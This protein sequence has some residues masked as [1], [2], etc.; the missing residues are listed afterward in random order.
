MKNHRIINHRVHGEQFEARAYTHA[1]THTRTYVNRH[2]RYARNVDR[3]TRAHT[4]TMGAH[5]E[6]AL[7]SERPWWSSVDDATTFSR[8]RAQPSWRRD[9]ST[10]LGG[11]LRRQ[12]KKRY[13]RRALPVERPSYGRLERYLQH[14]PQ[15]TKYYYY[16]YYYYVR[17]KV[18][19]DSA[20][21]S[22]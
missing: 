8:G 11:T 2:T 19:S 1:R 5:S 20:K 3:Q 18:S 9:I 16:Y 14:F 21:L 13:A 10:G 12:R 6:K 7:C 17:Y 4:H 15:N 22:F